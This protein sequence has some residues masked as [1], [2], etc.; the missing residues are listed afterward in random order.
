MTDSDAEAA[1]VKLATGIEGLDFVCE[2]G[3]PAGRLALV[4]GAVGTGKTILALQFLAR[5]VTLGDPG[6]FVTFEETPA[7]IRENMRSLGVDVAALERAGTWAFVDASRR[8]DTVA[9]ETGE[10][11]L[12]ALTARI[13]HAVEKIGARRVALDSLG[14]AMAQFS[15]T[16]LRRPHVFTLAAELK[17]MGVVSL[18]TSELSTLAQ[19][20]VTGFEDFV[21]D[22]VLVLRNTLSDERRRRTIEVLKMRGSDH[23]LG[24]YPFAIMP[25]RGIVVISL[26]ALE[27]AMP[28]GTQRTTSGIGDLDAMCGGGFFQNAVVLV[29]GATG[30]GKT[31]MVTSFIA[32]GIAAGQRSL[33]LGFEESP[34]QLRRNAAGWGLDLAAMEAAGELLVHCDYPERASLES[35]LIRITALV[36]EHQPTRLAIDSLSALERSASRRGFR[37]FVIALTNIL[38][39]RQITAMLTV[40]TP[41]LAEASI[42]E[43]HISTLTDGIILLRYVEFG[44]HIERAL[45]VLKMRGSPHDN[46]I[47]SFTIDDHGMHIDGPF[48]HVAG[49]LTGNVRPLPPDVAQRRAAPPGTDH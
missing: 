12:Q 9:V 18:L 5:G 40:S 7:A 20:N 16:A 38:K 27:L 3:L 13:R 31:L 44:G 26:A 43:T 24:Q 30:T 42:T 23:R 1:V 6:V 46:A 28:S 37:E 48:P 8:R 45:T 2:G 36:D 35:T 29:S 34:E 41:I 4:Q 14:A 15:P 11:D 39:Q 33:L 10:F 21:A 25:G 49:I 19:D 22:S 17:D 47:C 32:G